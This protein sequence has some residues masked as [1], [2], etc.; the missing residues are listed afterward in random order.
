MIGATITL[1]VGVAGVAG[2]LLIKHWEITRGR[3]FFADIRSRLQGGIRRA[4]WS[5]GALSSIF[6]RIGANLRS[7]VH[8]FAKTAF[9]RTLVALER[10]LERALHTVRKTKDSGADASGQ[11]ASPFLQEVVAYKKKLR[12]RAATLRKLGRE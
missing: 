12:P 6:V 5:G 7:L 3:V 1:G 8:Q 10:S 11:S 4:F 2:L 9:A